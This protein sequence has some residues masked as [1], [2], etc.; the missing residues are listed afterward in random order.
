MCSPEPNTRH[1]L[2]PCC[3]GWVKLV[4]WDVSYL[5]ADTFLILPVKL[6]PPHTRCLNTSA[7]HGKS[8]FS[9]QSSHE[10]CF[11]AGRQGA[12]M[13]FPGPKA[14]LEVFTQ[15]LLACR[16]SSLGKEFPSSM[17]TNFTTFLKC[18]N[19][20]KTLQFSFQA[21]AGESRGPQ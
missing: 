15:M 11:K 3:K 21:E 6:S 4:V 20:M 12:Q 17:D 9:M 7:Y 13:W 19:L 10:R 18:R 2:S 5:L 8:F 16:W 14:N 1:M